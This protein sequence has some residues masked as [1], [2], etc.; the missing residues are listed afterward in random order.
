MP[1]VNPFERL[2]H[3][4]EE[5]GLW[6]HVSPERTSLLL[7]RLMS[8]QDVTWSSGGAWRADG[9]D[10]AGGD[11]EHW[12]RGM[13]EPLGECGVP[14]AVETCS[15]PDGFR[16]D[17]YAVAVNG[18]TLHLYSV[19]PADPSL[20]LTDD[21]W[22]DCTTEPAAE[23]NRLLREAGSDRRIALFWPGG[24]DG[25]SVLGPESVLREAAA[26]TGEAE[27]A[28][29]FVIPGPTRWA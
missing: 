26:A 14:L 1:A 18:R 11:V 8:G 20:P 9:E 19:D 29:A 28:S 7:R 6:R 10:L 23:V 17:G 3:D 27:G 16:L 22:L 13:V 4:L 5:A 2:L 15:R 24:N 12:L 21:P 25:F